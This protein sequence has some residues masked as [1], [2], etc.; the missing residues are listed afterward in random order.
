MCKDKEWAKEHIE[1]VKD[2]FK[3]V[4]GIPKFIKK[5]RHL[6]DIVEYLEAKKEE[7][8]RNP[9]IPL[10]TLVKLAFF[11]ITKVAAV[12][13]NITEMKKF[14]EEHKEDIKK[15]IIAFKKG[16]ISKD[17]DKLK[18]LIQAKLAKIKMTITLVAD[19]FWTLKKLKVMFQEKGDHEVHLPVGFSDKEKGFLEGAGRK[20]H[21][22]KEM[23]KACEEFVEKSEDFWDHPSFP[24]KKMHL[25]RSIFMHKLGE[26]VKMAPF[27]YKKLNFMHHVFEM[28]LEQL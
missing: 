14:A 19:T 27:L 9:K 25:A 3:G 17:G 23:L 18:K 2:K 24:W 22:M 26:L 12:M 15:A 4:E 1:E 11:K 5:L 20:L 13:K 28:K 16:E 21:E 7:S 10:K 8:E 6:K